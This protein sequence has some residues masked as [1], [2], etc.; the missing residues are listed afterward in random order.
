M[1]EVSLAEKKSVNGKPCEPTRVEAHY[2]TACRVKGHSSMV[3]CIHKWVSNTHTHSE[4]GGSTACAFSLV[5]SLANS[6]MLPYR[7][8]GL[9]I[10]HGAAWQL[11]GE[12]TWLVKLSRRH[13]FTQ[14]MYN[15]GG[16]AYSAHSLYSSHGTL[17]VCESSSLS[18]AQFCS[19]FFVPFL[20]PVSKRNEVTSQ[21][22]ATTNGKSSKFGESH[23]SRGFFFL[24]L[25]KNITKGWMQMCAHT[26]WA[27][28]QWLVVK[29]LTRN[30]MD[31]AES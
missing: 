12:E 23:G 8:G 14:P 3:V 18:C 11:R 31:C 9:Y 5:P 15:R 7:L 10:L 4:R 24:L 21:W 26:V 6:E 2:Y 29:P 28:N 16:Q 30:P 25:F 20:L 1:P 19:H 13:S 17:P 22:K 27:H